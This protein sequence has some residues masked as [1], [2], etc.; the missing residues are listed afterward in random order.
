MELVAPSDLI[1]TLFGPAMYVGTQLSCLLPLRDG[2]QASWWNLV[3]CVTYND[4]LRGLRSAPR[5]S[6]LAGREPAEYLENTLT[7][8]TPSLAH[9][10]MDVLQ[11]RR[12]SQLATLLVSSSVPVRSSIWSGTASR[13]QHRKH[14]L[15]G[16]QRSR[17]RN[18]QQRTRVRSPQTLAAHA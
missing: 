8:W 9:E 12:T 5:H 3:T 18:Q 15:L 13:C 4:H 11:Q 16:I 14:E 2:Q 17:D 10:P 7:E 1:E 6:R